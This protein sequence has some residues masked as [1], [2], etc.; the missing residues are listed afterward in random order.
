MEVGRSGGKLN[1]T[2]SVFSGASKGETKYGGVFWYHCD[3]KHS[4][5]LPSTTPWTGSKA[6][7]W[8]NGNVPCVG[9]KHTVSSGR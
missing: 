7:A 8:A 6:C 3:T 9:C 5:P 4:G 1:V 2:Q